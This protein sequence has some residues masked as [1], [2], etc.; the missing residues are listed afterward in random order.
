MEN[1]SLTNCQRDICETVYQNLSNNRKSVFLVCGKP[2]TGKTYLI[3]NIAKYL[4]HTDENN[5]F[6]IMLAM[7]NRAAKH[8]GGSTINSYFKMDYRTGSA[9]TILNKKISK[10]YLSKS[11]FETFD[12]VNCFKYVESS[13]IKWNPS[14]RIYLN[15]LFGHTHSHELFDNCAYSNEPSQSKTII[16]IDECSMIPIWLIWAI[17]IHFDKVFDKYIIILLGDRNQT[18]PIVFPFSIFNFGITKLANLMNDL[19]TQEFQ[20]L[21][22]KRFNPAYEQI[23][24]KFLEFYENIAI[25]NVEKKYELLVNLKSFLANHFDQPLSNIIYADNLIDIDRVL[26]FYNHRVNQYNSIYIHNL[27]TQPYMLRGSLHLSNQIKPLEITQEIE[28]ILGTIETLPKVDLLLKIDCL[29]TPINNTASLKNGISYRVV[30]YNKFVDTLILKTD[31]DHYF[32]IMR[33]PYKIANRNIIQL[34]GLKNQPNEQLL[35]KQFPLTLNYA[36]TIHKIQGET[37]DCNIIIDVVDVNNKI[38]PEILY[39]AISRV[40]D[41]NQIKYIIG[42]KSDDYA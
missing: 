3:E 33:E 14:N 15:E 9:Y 5:I 38:T 24:N 35:F 18:G 27:K 12:Y 26:C 22:N 23:V 32:E 36:T 2:G 10:K 20:L 7:T 40:R 34:L 13:T 31:K 16:F 11:G 29:V 25:D 1:L 39:T 17:I 30:R 6:S 37:L 42:L 8:I 4:K 28:D 21:V 41:K 19:Y